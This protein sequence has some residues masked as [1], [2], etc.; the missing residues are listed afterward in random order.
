LFFTTLNPL[1]HSLVY[2]DQSQFPLACTLLL[3]FLQPYLS[4]IGETAPE[5]ATK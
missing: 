3:Y 2:R 5:L 1:R 4:K